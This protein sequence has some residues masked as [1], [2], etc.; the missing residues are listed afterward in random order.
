MNVGVNDVQTS[1][2]VY[3]VPRPPVPDSLRHKM[4]GEKSSGTGS[5][6]TV[7]L[8][9][10]NQIVRCVPEWQVPEDALP[11]GWCASS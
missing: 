4:Y 8:P 2:E 10:S 6:P 7:L 5:T 1:V 3:S 11:E 9:T